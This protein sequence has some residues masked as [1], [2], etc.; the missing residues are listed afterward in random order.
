MLSDILSEPD[1][2]PGLPGPA[3]A[4]EGQTSAG[5]SGAGFIFISSIRSAQTE[6]LSVISGT[7]P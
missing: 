4:P 1:P 3:V 2:F 7:C 6:M 5:E